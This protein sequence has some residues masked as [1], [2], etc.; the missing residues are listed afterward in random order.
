MF[1]IFP[2]H[3]LATGLYDTRTICTPSI[4]DDQLP[5]FDWAWLAAAR[6]VIEFNLRDLL[7]KDRHQGVLRAFLSLDGL[8][9]CSTPGFPFTTPKAVVVRGK[10]KSRRAFR[11]GEGRD[12]AG[13][14][15][16]WRCVILPLLL[17][18]TVVLKKSQPGAPI[19]DVSVG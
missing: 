14:E 2:L 12:W 8:R 1:S 10:G 17:G 5:R 13:V 7:R 9:S 19:D 6:Q 3:S 11:D 18:R 4:Q 16:Q 15:G